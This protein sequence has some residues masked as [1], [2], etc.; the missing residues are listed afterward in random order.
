MSSWIRR[1]NTVK[2]SNFPLLIYWFN[3]MPIKHPP[4]AWW[5][6][7]IIKYL[8]GRDQNDCSSR[9]GQAKC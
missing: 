1:V 8:G 5:P 4:I 3:K 6:M 2:K 7:P 9:P